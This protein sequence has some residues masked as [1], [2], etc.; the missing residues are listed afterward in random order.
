MWSKK[1]EGFWDCGHRGS[2]GFDEVLDGFHGWLIEGGIGFLSR[3]NVSININVIS[4]QRIGREI[5]TPLIV[6]RAFPAHP[7]IV[8]P[9]H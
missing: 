5:V 3:T 7:S 2:R 9:P 8:G 6:P 4:D 1:F